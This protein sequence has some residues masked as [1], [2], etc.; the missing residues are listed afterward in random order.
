[1]FQLQRFKGNILHDCQGLTENLNEKKKGVTNSF[2]N[3]LPEDEALEDHGL[4]PRDFAHWKGH[5]IKDALQPGWKDLYQALL[6]LPCAAK[7]KT[8]Y[9]RI[10]IA[11]LKKS[12]C[13]NG[14]QETVG[15]N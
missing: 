9:L 10:H 2:H 4:Q 8:V 5:Q 1:M 3:K 12:L 7:L 11:H 6:T 15:F 13:Q 14:L